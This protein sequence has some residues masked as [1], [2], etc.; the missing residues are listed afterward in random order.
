MTWPLFSWILSSSSS[1]SSSSAEY[2]FDDEAE[3]QDSP[4]DVVSCDQAEYFDDENDG[5]DS[6]TVAVIGTADPSSST[7]KRRRTDEYYHE[8]EALHLSEKRASS[9][10]R[11]WAKEDEVELLQSFLDYTIS[12]R[13]TG[14]H[15]KSANSFYNDQVKPELRLRFSKTQL[16]EKLRRLK[17][18][19]QNTLAKLKNSSVDFRFKSEHDRGIFEISQKIWSS[20]VDH[21]QDAVDDNTLLSL[22]PKTRSRTRNSGELVTGTKRSVLDCDESETTGLVM[23][24][25]LKPLS[26]GFKFGDGEVGDE[27]WREQQ[28]VELEVYSKRLELVQG[29]VKDAL[30]KL[31]STGS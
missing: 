3:D 25:A 31:R 29:Q 19:Y 14:P 17:G 18:K 26:F 20:V 6:V 1:S 5:V 7:S 12:R 11:V 16:G 4:N 10:K 23:D 8:S 2:E 9:Q 24:L 28:I 30:E 21:D 22:R 15:Q 13:R 27:K